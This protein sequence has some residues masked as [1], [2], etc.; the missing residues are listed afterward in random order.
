MAS[1]FYKFDLGKFKCISVNDGGYDFPLD[2]IFSNVPAD[3]IAPILAV[4]GLPT[5]RLHTPYSLLFVDNGRQ[6]LLVDVGGGNVVPTSGKMRGN[7]IAAGIDPLTVDAVIITHAHPDHVGGIIDD[8]GSLTYPN[9]HYYIWQKEWDFW[10]S[11]KAEQQA[12]EMHVSLARNRL[13][14]IK[15]RVTF[16]EPG[17]EIFPGIFGVDAAGHTPGHMNL[18]IISEGSQ[19][20][21]I[22]DTALSPLHIENPDWQMLFEIDPTQAQKSKGRI[23]N[24]AADEEALV[25]AHHFPPFPALGTIIKKGDGWQWQPLQ[26]S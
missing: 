22:S 14:Y 19:L 15:E 6:R 17:S 1:D 18:S 11:E 5:N 7:L 9:A 10:W 12:L 21:H 26:I 2:I 20:L 24:R 16:V 25:F 4:R 13:S 23:F 8:E 3:Q